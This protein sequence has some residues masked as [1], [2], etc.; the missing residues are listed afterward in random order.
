M[1]TK[2]KHI[3]IIISM[4]LILTLFATNLSPF[5]QMKMTVQAASDPQATVTKY[6]LFLGYKDYQIKIRNAAKTATI[7]YA[8]SD[9][10]VASVSKYGLVKP[11]A[12]GK[13]VITVKIYQN[14]KYYTSKINVT[15]M[16]SYMDIY[17]KTNKINIGDIFTFE[18]TSYG[19]AYNQ[20]YWS[21]S[22]K[23]VA[24]I[25]K[26]SGQLKALSAGT[27]V[28][29]A[30][31]NKSRIKS[32]L[33]VTVKAKETV[34]SAPTVEPTVSLSPTVE[35]T[36]TPPL[37]VTYTPPDGCD[38]AVY[39]SGLD[40]SKETGVYY[41]TTKE[42]Y[43]QTT[44]FNLYLDNNVQVPVNV[45]DLINY[46][47]DT[48]EQT[49]G[50]KFYTK[51]YNDNK[52][53]QGI[54]YILDEYFN[55]ATTFKSI[56][57]K[58]ERLDIVVVSDYPNLDSLSTNNGGI[59][60][61]AKHIKLLDG[62]ANSLIYE[63]L[64]TVYLQNGSSMGYA[65]DEGFASYYTANIIK[66]DNKLNC[67][68]DTYKSLSNYKTKIS[69]DIMEYVFI[70]YP[71]WKDKQFGFRLTCYIME[72]YGQDLYKKLH[73]T[74]TTA[75]G[76]DY[77]LS[78][79][80]KSQIIKNTLSVDF[81]KDFVKWYNLNYK[82][83]G[84]TDLLSVNDWSLTPPVLYNYYGDDTNVVIPNTVLYIQD[85]AF[86]FCTTMVNVNIPNS[87]TYIGG[88]AFFG[89][90]N[91]TEATIP[92]SVTSISFDSFNRCANLKKITLSKSIKQISYRTF[93]NCTSLSSIEISEGVSLIQ[94]EAFYNCSSLE[95]V[96][97]PS[98]LNTIE[99]GAFFSSGIK[100]VIIP[101]NVVKIGEQAFANCKN[102]KSVT[103]P[104][105]VKTIYSS[106]FFN[107]NN[108]TIYG[109]KGS[110]AE[111]YAKENKIA[112]SEIKK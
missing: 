19:I 47:M 52:F 57:A 7:T 105:S 112:F 92:D 66:N 5:S 89:C 91:L 48:V 74:I 63:L 51:H 76:S 11:L 109:E 68:Y 102:L 69:E 27:T 73:S 21:S 55:S 32:E 37:T 46:I 9:K 108:V 93:Y 99:H 75:V 23:A 90:N 15:V 31:D 96:V 84:D 17:R 58:D 8:S 98:T 41:T 16:N 67:N 81:F 100:N 87:V 26:I 61:R 95:T 39:L 10:T 14:K 40:L 70:N 54:D 110:Y 42:E 50:Y 20:I 13:A 36:I 18:A 29:T 56:D 49:T 33:T 106:S 103:I 111:I 3:K 101:D 35:P 72:R 88:R 45:I 104:S 82:R 79:D 25:D 62:S 85:G 1:N 30:K 6:T 78:M 44:R 28:I 65:L 38:K 86:M 107:S 59:I 2:K 12:L 94:Y 43:I 77:R 4:A 97:L 60:L 83:F 24:T 53:Y 64:R 22:N 34:T 80:K 71:E